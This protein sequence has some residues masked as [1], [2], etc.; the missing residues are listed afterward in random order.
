MNAQT[1]R[2]L[3]SHKSTNT[4]EI[5]IGKTSQRAITIDSRRTSIDRDLLLNVQNSTETH[6]PAERLTESQNTPMHSNSFY[7]S[8]RNI[9]TVT[10]P[11]TFN[12]NT[13][14]MR[15]RAASAALAPTTH[16]QYLYCSRAATELCNVI[17]LVWDIIRQCLPQFTMNIIGSSIVAKAATH[18]HCSSSTQHICCTR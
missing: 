5:R 16:S 11:Y 14:Q 10:H 17:V 7:I 15:S 8:W 9:P 2:R 13:R 4:R 3:F 1:R 6:T 18:H 12:T